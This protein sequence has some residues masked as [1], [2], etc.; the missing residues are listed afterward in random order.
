MEDKG[1]E[2]SRRVAES[3]V[4]GVSLRCSLS[5]V[6]KQ[7]SSTDRCRSSSSSSSS[8][9]SNYVVRI[10]CLMANAG[11]AAMSRIKAS[12]TCHLWLRLISFF[13]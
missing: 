8:R 7:C 10:E 6:S 4:S 11:T 13:P 2:L 9:S 1:D 5:V 3:T 12:F